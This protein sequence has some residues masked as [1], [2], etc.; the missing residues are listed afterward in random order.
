MYPTKSY[1]S[2]E[3]QIKHALG[4]AQIQNGQYGVP[5]V[6]GAAGWCAFDYN[7]H[8]D[9]GSG[10]RICYHGVCDIFRLPKF[11]AHFYRSQME[12][13]KQPVVFIARYLIPSFNEDF[14][15]VVPVFT[16][17]EEADLFINGVKVASERPDYVNYPSLPHPPIMFTGCSWWEWGSSLLTSLKVVG[18]IGGAAVAEHELF[19][20]GMPDQLA[21]LADDLELIADGADCTRVVVALQDSKGQTLQLAHHAVSFHVEGPGRLIGENPFSLEAGRGAVY[22]Q[23]TRTP[24]TIRCIAMVK[25]VMTAEVVIQTVALQDQIVSVPQRIQQLN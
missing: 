21:L 22:I 5:Y 19:P 25:G 13:S 3:R 7:T 16:N 14:R 8:Q 18:K 24:G 12:P 11:A 15:D 2:V 4:H 20:V 9:F 17:C 23:A 6:A 10:D 1:D